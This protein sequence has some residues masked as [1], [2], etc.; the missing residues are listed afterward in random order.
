M[1]YHFLVLLSPLF[2][3]SACN[4]SSNSDSP[5]P[6]PQERPQED[7]GK[8]VDNSPPPS[9]S[10]APAS[11]DWAQPPVACAE[12]VIP[13]PAQRV[14]LD[15]STIKNIYSDWPE[16]ITAADKTYWLSQPRGL[17]YC[18]AKELLRREELQPGT[19][20]PGDVETAWMR[21][22]AIQFHKEKVTAVYEAS[23]VHGMPTQ[24]LTGALFQESLFSQLGVAADGGN[25]SC[26]LGQVNIS[27]WCN[28]ALQQSDA[29]KIDMRFPMVLKT[30]NQAQLPFLKPLYEIALTKL[31]GE[32]EYKL[33]PEHFKDI[34]LQDVVAAWPKADPIIQQARFDLI[35]SFLGN[36][37][38]PKDGIAAKANQLA[39][40]YKTYVPSGLKAREFY[41]PGDR[42]RR[43]CRGGGNELSYPLSSAWLLAVGIY[44]SGPRS[45]DA[46]A[47]YNNWTEADLKKSE[48]FDA[49]NPVEMVTSFYWA[50][51]YN[52]VDDK[53]HFRGRNGNDLSWDWFKGCVL[54]RHVARVA[55][56][57]TLPGTPR[58]IDSL[59]N[60]FPCKKASRDPVTGDLISGVPDFRKVSPGHK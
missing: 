32:P 24:I 16:D 1:K 51:K 42:Y 38:D 52:P 9:P 2:L 41:G 4:S 12:E 45:V 57:V 25:Y 27:E 15:L 39:T 55:Q 8:P 22:L 18:R 31:Q 44:N 34:Q 3:L 6:P 11:L 10:P 26:G 20:P 14:C 54:Q 13:H 48:T 53:I 28:W 56:H 30:C 19:Y 23:R 58:F 33:M 5:A 29:K 35:K 40:I 36:C 47:F 46:L 17:T 50:G 7:P 59:E 43:S 37:R 49:F 60:G 21:A